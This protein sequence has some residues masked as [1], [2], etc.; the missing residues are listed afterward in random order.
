[1]ERLILD[2]VTKEARALVIRYETFPISFVIR[3][4]RVVVSELIRPDRAVVSVEILSDR[5]ASV[6]CSVC[7]C[8]VKILIDEVSVALVVANPVESRDDTFETR[9]FA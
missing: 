7:I 4:E 9:V 3:L 5:L 8:W 1:L 2:W 6:A